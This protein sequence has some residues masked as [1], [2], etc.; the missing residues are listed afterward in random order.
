[1]KTLQIALNFIA[2]CVGKFLEIASYLMVPV[3]IILQATLQNLEISVVMHW[4]NMAMLLFGA[5]VSTY[6]TSDTEHLTPRQM[7]LRAAFAFASGY[8]GVDQLVSSLPWLNV[9]LAYFISGLAMLVICTI[10]LKFLKDFE[11][12]AILTKYIKDKLGIK[13]KENQNIE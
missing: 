9:K 11:A 13:E 8:A 5:S 10:I 7:Y 2:D 6:I 1:M 4:Q 12:K 3:G